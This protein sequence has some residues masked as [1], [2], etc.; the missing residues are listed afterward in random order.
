[1]ALNKTEGRI[2][3]RI[4]RGDE[5]A[6]PEFREF[7]K[8][9]PELVDGWATWPTEVLLKRIGA[10]TPVVEPPMLPAPGLPLFCQES[11]RFTMNEIREGLAP[12]PSPI[13]KLL[14]ERIVAC[15]L[16]VYE[17]DLRCALGSES[18]YDLH[19]QDRAHRRLLSACR[20]LATVCR[21]ALPMQIDL[22]VAGVVKT[23]S[24]ATATAERFALPV[25]GVN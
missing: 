4:L 22:N 19:R 10:M 2:I 11:L 25:V 9:H 15:W 7:L 23:E 1:V 17:A 3:A 20:T 5:T 21:L 14:T 18:A 6:V 12:K 16:Q 24:T 13:E 8:T